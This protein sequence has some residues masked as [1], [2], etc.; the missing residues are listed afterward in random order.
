MSTQLQALPK[1]STGENERRRSTRVLLVIPVEV[2]WT[3]RE[4]SGCSEKAE[5]E[6]VSQH[7]AM[8]RMPT[9]LAP[10]TKLRINRQANQQSCE[11]RVVGVGNPSPDG[12]ARVAV[13]MTVPSDAFWGVSFPP[14]TAA[15]APAKPLP[16]PAKLAPASAARLAPASS[17]PRPR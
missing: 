2:A 12:L 10:G 11:A 7:G 6:V 4:G 15:A 1:N 5:T 13:E 8:L 16:L 17:S 14:V 9:R 3:T